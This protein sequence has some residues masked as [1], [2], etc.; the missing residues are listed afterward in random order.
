MFEQCTYLTRPRV[1]RP[2]S[3]FAAATVPR[4]PPTTVRCPSRD[5]SVYRDGFGGASRDSGYRGDQ[6][7]RDEDTRSSRCPEEVPATL[8]TAHAFHVQRYTAGGGPLSIS[9]RSA[10]VT[11]LR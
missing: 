1:S 5:G 8:T 2:M 3:I 11:S 7:G 4:H 10:C 6:R 9:R